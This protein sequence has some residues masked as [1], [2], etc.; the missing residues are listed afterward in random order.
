MKLMVILKK[1]LSFLTSAAMALTSVSGAF[2]SAVYAETPSSGHNEIYS[3]T[4]TAQISAGGVIGE[5]LSSELDTSGLNDNISCGVTD[6][7]ITGNIASVSYFSDSDGTIIVGLYSDDGTELIATGSQE[8]S[9]ENDA[10]DIIIETNVMPEF[11]DVKAYIVDTETL[12]PMSMEFETP[13]YTKNMHEFL[14]L[15]TEDFDEELVVNLDTDSEDNFLVYSDSLIMI[16]SYTESD[17]NK[18]VSADSEKNIYVFSDIDEN[19]SGLKVGDT[20]WYE[21]EKDNILCDKVSGITFS[22]STA[23]VTC[24]DFQLEDAFAAIKISAESEN[25]S[26]TPSYR[27]TI[28][29]IDG[30]TLPS[31]DD[32]TEFSFSKGGESGAFEGSVSLTGSVETTITP[33]VTVYF[34]KAL[35]VNYAKLECG[36]E[37]ELAISGS[38]NGSFSPDIPGKNIP[39]VEP[40]LSIEIKPEIE[41]EIEIAGSVT[42]VYA[43]SVGFTAHAK[44]SEYLNLIT[45]YDINRIGEPI[46]CE[47]LTASCAI[48]LTIT[49]ALDI[50]LAIPTS[51]VLALGI[52]VSIPITAE[53][54]LIE[55]ELF[56]SN[57]DS[58]HG[59][60]PGECMSGA[61]TVDIQVFPV[62][63]V[64][65][66]N[67]LEL[68]DTDAS[69]GREFGVLIPIIDEDEG[70]FFIRNGK[71]HWG[72][73]PYYVYKNT[74]YIC[75]SNKAPIPDASV[76][77]SGKFI[78]P[79]SDVYQY[80]N[81][82]G[83]T[84]KNGEFTIYLP[85]SLYS[86]EVEAE[87]Y[88]DP[89]SMYS[90]GFYIRTYTHSQRQQI[91][92]HE[93]IKDV[94]ILTPPDKTE[95]YKYQGID[96]TGGQLEVKYVNGKTEIIPIE[97][98]MIYGFSS[99]TPCDELPV[100]VDYH[101]FTDTFNVTVKDDDRIPQR[102]EMKDL[103]KTEYKLGE[104]LS[105][106]GGTINL[107]YIIYI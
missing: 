63:Y 19:I 43:G 31:Y 41:I 80:I 47:S 64:G 79:D 45:G 55:K 56:K 29:D 107:Y 75:D 105:L 103:P 5:A 66:E 36:V 87:G 25:L 38:A 85:V 8:I 6:V 27:G 21:Y 69:I 26:D 34:A 23:T 1:L 33:E 20:F 51:K 83:T 101:G 81:E 96:L 72:S 50:M 97:F 24:G 7:T 73:C 77:L 88:E 106:T 9:A 16:P 102:I 98:Y 89:F 86:I 65:G 13:M 76:S 49:P 46:H 39:V 30:L 14:Q 18:V 91:I 15:T 12:R 61:I 17:K 11:F 92:L 52:Q 68:E 28:D 40:V 82:K 78:V 57:M 4:G 100:T 48:A 95:Y 37:F 22:G 90:D 58:K 67:G 62:I 99:S 104:S 94:K 54:A 3:G 44:R 10:A 60:A 84:D 2:S 35:E 32:T 93:K 74:F 70:A 53:V 59:C 42:A 71:F